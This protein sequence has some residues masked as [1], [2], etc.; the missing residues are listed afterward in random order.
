MTLNQLDS[1]DIL[2]PDGVIDGPLARS[3]FSVF[4]LCM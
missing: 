2:E 4:W 3:C 1:L